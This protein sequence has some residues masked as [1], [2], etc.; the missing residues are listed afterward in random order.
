MRYTYTRGYLLI[1]KFSQEI[2]ILTEREREES[3]SSFKRRNRSEWELMEEKEEILQ[4]AFE[5]AYQEMME[6]EFVS[7]N[8][9]KDHRS[10]YYF[11]KFHVIPNTPDFDV[12]MSDLRLSYLQGLMWCLSYYVKGCISWNWFYP[13]HYGPLLQD[14]TNLNAL[15]SKIEFSIGQP[16]RPFQ[17]LLGC[18]PPASSALVP[19]PYSWLMVSAQSPLLAFYPESFEVDSDGKKNPWEAVIKLP[20]I[21][22]RILFEAEAEYCSTSKLS[23]NEQR[24]NTFGTMSLFLYN[25]SIVE[26]YFSCNPEIGLPDVTKCQSSVVEI[27][28]SINP[29]KAFKSEL[30]EG[31][32]CPCAGFPCLGVITFHQVRTEFLKIN[33]FGSESKY[34][35]VVLEMPSMAVDLEDIPA[36]VSRLIGSSVFVNFPLMHEARVVGVSTVSDEYRLSSS[37]DIIITPHDAT[38]AQKWA[39][40]SSDEVIFRDLL[41]PSKLILGAKIRRRQRRSWD[42]RARDRLSFC[43]FTS[44]SPP[45]CEAKSVDWKHAQGLRKH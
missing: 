25:P 36:M 44:L 20:F 24:R 10:R 2:D 34:R 11:D 21:D 40:D 18:L 1:F 6:S 27:D 38:T 28:F 31:T 12:L 7:S 41:V 23:M 13:Y 39:K 14:M 33:V 22:E 37:G 42:W 9:E 29:G 30:I 35:S 16:F 4:Q 17:Q 3:L 26:T 15:T 43:S 5:D 19:K 45:R 32:T 8:D